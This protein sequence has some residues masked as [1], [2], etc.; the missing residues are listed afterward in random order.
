[1]RARCPQC[2]QK[3]P[4]REFR[5]KHSPGYA[6]WCRGC[7]ELYGKGGRAAPRRGLRETGELRVQF[8]PS[9]GGKKTGPIP[10]TISSAETCP[11][12]CALRGSGCFAEH[13]FL[14]VHWS[15]VPERGDDWDTFLQKLEALPE[16]TLWRHNDAGDLPGEGDRLDVGRLREL[17][18]ANRGL[19]GFT[20]THKP[21]L[22]KR[23]RDA[24]RAA[25][26]QGF[27]VNLS[28]DSPADADRLA[29]L[30]IGPVATVVPPGTRTGDRTP[31]GRRIVVCPEQTEARLTCKRC[32]LCQIADRRGIVGFFPHGPARRRLPLVR[33]PDSRQ[34]RV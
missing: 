19:R 8:V 22:T 21:L 26:R 1:M 24:V 2:W 10:V 15:K 23:E 17:V 34:D 27:T 4:K 30:D 13:H 28:A 3:K 20:Y 11:T 12:S 33:A 16:G 29:M 32:Q 5:R 6:R 25:N 31:G 7:R 9:S 18:R 14:R